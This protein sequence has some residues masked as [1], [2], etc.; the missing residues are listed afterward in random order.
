MQLDVQ[1]QGALGRLRGL[2]RHVGGRERR[3]S[4]NVDVIGTGV[5][6]DVAHSNAAL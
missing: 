4:S 1:L 2:E 3:Q 5:G 6:V